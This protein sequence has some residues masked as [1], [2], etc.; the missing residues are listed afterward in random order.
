MEWLRLYT[1]SNYHAGPKSKGF[2]HHGKHQDDTVCYVSHPLPQTERCPYP[3][4][5]LMAFGSRA[6][7]RSLSLEKVMRAGLLHG[8]I[9]VVMRRDGEVA[10]D[11]APCRVRTWPAAP[12]KL[13]R[14]PSPETELAGTLILDFPAASRTLRINFSCSSHSVY[15]ILVQQ[16]ELNK[17]PVEL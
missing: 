4:P 11:P 2:W 12:G 5:V 1:H 10:P 15:G 3:S 7:E 9:S 16:P 17:I 14:E 6:T 8:G 13:G